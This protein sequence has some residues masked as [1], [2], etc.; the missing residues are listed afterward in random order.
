[1]RARVL[2]PDRCMALPMFHAFAGCDTVSIFGGKTMM[3]LHQHFQC[4]LATTPE[5]VESFIYKPLE[6]F[7]ILLYDCTSNL[8]CVNRARKQLFTQKGTSVKGI[9][10]TKA[11]LIQHIKPATYQAGYCWGQVMIA[12]PEPPSPNDWSWTRREPSG[13][14]VCSTT[15]PAA[16]KA[17]RELLRCGCKKSC[18]HQCKCLKAALQCTT[19]CHCGGL[20][21]E[22]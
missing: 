16:T 21:S 14:E 2:E 18:T 5:S 20:C 7:V 15:L 22:N 13:W 8:E 4:S 3:K 1:M 11:V 10:P 6:Q 17:C 12:A 19:L 9:L